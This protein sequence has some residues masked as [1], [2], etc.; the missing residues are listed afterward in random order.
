M[1]RELM[2]SFQHMKD[3]RLSKPTTSTQWT[4]QLVTQFRAL[5]SHTIC[6]QSKPP[7]S[8]HHFKSTIGK[9]QCLLFNTWEHT[10]VSNP[11]SHDVG[12]L[13]PDGKQCSWELSYLVQMSRAAAKAAARDQK[14]AYT[15]VQIT[16][17]ILD[18]RQSKQRA[19]HPTLHSQTSWLMYT[20]ADV[21]QKCKTVLLVPSSRRGSFSP[22]PI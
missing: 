2:C 8:Y 6:S 15:A 18:S 3:H 14:F 21:Q 5:S 9:P 7:P 11:I 1:V 13:Q 10:A 20:A 16:Q 22:C 4:P 17:V 19:A 12:R